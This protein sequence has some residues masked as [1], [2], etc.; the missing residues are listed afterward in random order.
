VLGAMC[1]G[2][3]TPLDMFMYYDARPCQMNGLFESDT[4][5]C[6]KPYYSFVAFNEL[7]KLGYEIPCE[8][9]VDDIYSCAAT[10]GKDSAIA[11][12]YYNDDEASCE[13]E[14]KVSFTNMSGKKKAI[15]CYLDAMNNLEPI[16]EEIF[17]SDEFSLYLK[18]PLY[19]S[20]LVKIE[21][22]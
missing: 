15:C 7:V 5:K 9:F 21:S 1:I 20:V 17:T 12:T 3:A 4:Y 18:M 16:R 8:Y 14:V 6:L 13:K 2:Q 11:L 19:T 10:N 22:I